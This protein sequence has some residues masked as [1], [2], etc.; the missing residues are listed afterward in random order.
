MCGIAGIVDSRG[1]VPEL[2][3]LEAM[4]RALQHRG[5]DGGGIYRFPPDP[6]ADRSGRTAVGLVHRRLSVIDLE[7]GHQP[8]ANE[9]GTVWV[10]FNGEIYNFLELRVEL[11]TRG[12]RFQTRSDTEVLVHA[13]EE[14]GA[15]LVEKLRGMFAFALW[16]QRRERLLLARDRVGKKPLLYAIIN[17]RLGFA[18]E[19]RAL[20]ASGLIP[21]EVDWEA[22]RLYLAWMCIP[23][24]RTAFR[25]IK[26][27]PPAHYLV[28]ENGQ[29]KVICYW[30]LAYTPKWT[31]SEA[32]TEERL[33]EHLTEAVRVRLESDVPLGVFLSGG[34]DSSAVVGL[35]SQQTTDPIRTFS[36]GFE[37][38]GYNELPHAREVASHFATDHQ[39]FVVKPR[40][41]EVLPTLVERF[42]EPFADS[43]AI[44]TYYLAKLAR[45]HVTVVLNGDG[46]DEVF[47]GY[48]RHLGAV[49]AGRL[50]RWLRPGGMAAVQGLIGSLP[51]WGG[52]HSRWA[53]MQRFIKAVHLPSHERYRRW[54]GFF[55]D[56]LQKELWNAVNLHRV[57]E[58]ASAAV[59]RLF[60]KGSGLDPL[61]SMLMVDTMFYLPS[62]LLVKMDIA[63]MAHGLE[64]R[65]PL[66]DH[67]LMEFVARLPASMKVKG[68]R[69][70][71]IFK[72]TLNGLLEPHVLRRPKR[73]FVVPLA[74]WFRG[75]LKEFLADHL[76]GPS[77]VSGELFHRS[78]V[79]RLVDSHLQSREDYSHHLW[80]L[81][82]LELWYRRFIASN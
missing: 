73:G 28:F 40:A 70:K 51:V 42:G 10:V 23:A 31:F 69:L 14:Y 30:K 20:L 6:S 16:D 67:H 45:Q 21:R 82:M 60:A 8:M 9:D 66:L 46:G 22:I 13:Y 62:D 55:S 59:E 33:M 27:L 54:T 32:E 57:E 5:P 44:P 2:G 64:A 12:H 11:E 81:L 47:A 29:A 79:A 37:E 75:D 63:T 71:A 35:M 17:G 78:T 19:F 25:H 77:S 48:K 36:M 18:S 43:S 72:Q 80:I 26:K 15:A 24:P 41:I 3:C 68:F 53:S 1:R 39:E 61:D 74:I 65:S 58:T 52:R 76:L 4:S 7:G 34:I 49:F 50:Q 56:P 38:T